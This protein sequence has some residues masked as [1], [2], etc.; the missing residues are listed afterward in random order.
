MYALATVAFE[1]MT[2]SLPFDAENQLRILPMKAFRDPP[3]L[4]DIAKRQFPA[5]VEAVIARGLSRDPEQRYRGAGEFVASLELAIEQ[6]HVPSAEGAAALAARRVAAAS[7]PAIT[8]TSPL[9]KPRGPAE[10]AEMPLGA[11]DQFD[12]EALEASA[13][14][15]RGARQGAM[16][17]GGVALAAAG[18]TVPSIRPSAEVPRARGPLFAIA[19]AAIVLG[20]GGLAF[21]LLT[22]SDEAPAKVPAARPREVAPTAK[23]AR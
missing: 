5:A 21:A 17:L 1:L 10:S 11:S 12:L 15:A 18:E 20:L 9:P 13:A 14:P 2:G 6:G 19:G 3:R 22:D 4:A 7:D 23:T 8:P 16:T